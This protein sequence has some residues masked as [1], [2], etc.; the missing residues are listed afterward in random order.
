M[1]PL[2]RLIKWV[3][4]IGMYAFDLPRITCVF[5]TAFCNQHCYNQKFYRMYPR[6]L[7]YDQSCLHAWETC[8]LSDWILALERKRKSLARFRWATRGDVCYSLESAQKVQLIAKYFPNTLF[9]VPTRAW[10]VPA[11]WKEI[12]TLFAEVPNV[13]L[14]ASVDPSNTEVELSWLDNQGISTLF[15]GDNSNFDWRIKC[16]K[17]WEHTE[18]NCANCNVCFG[19]NQVHVH[20]KKH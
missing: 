1:L 20:L 14:M 8:T 15:F 5:R 16:V 10:R 6:M 2:G 19:H 4:G 9:W 7:A 18:G 17:T 13:K 11:T 12:R 3:D